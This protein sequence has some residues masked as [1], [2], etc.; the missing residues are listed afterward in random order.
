MSGNLLRSGWNA[1]H[2]SIPRQS[3]WLWS[4]VLDESCCEHQLRC[5]GALST[6]LSLVRF[7]HERRIAYLDLKGQTF[8]P[9]SNMLPHSPVPAGENCLID[10]HGYLKIIDFGVAERVRAVTD[11]CAFPTCATNAD[12]ARL[13]MVAYML[14]APQPDVRCMRPFDESEASPGFQGCDLRP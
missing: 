13:P 8:S 2:S 11:E 10:Q 1:R 5:T 9:S 7:L 4:R 6:R 3:Y 12:C 14:P